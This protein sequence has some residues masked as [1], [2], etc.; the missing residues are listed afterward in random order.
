MS[1][2]YCCGLRRAEL[3]N[4][5]KLWTASDSQLSNFG[6]LFISSAHHMKINWKPR[7]KVPLNSKYLLLPF[8]NPHIHAAQPP[9]F[10]PSSSFVSLSPPR[11]PGQRLEPSPSARLSIC[12]RPGL[13]LLL[14]RQMSAPSSWAWR[15]VCVCVC[16]WGLVSG[17]PVEGWPLPGGESALTL[18]GTIRG[19]NGMDEPGRRRVVG[20]WLPVWASPCKHAFIP[21]W[22][23]CGYV[24]QNKSASFVRL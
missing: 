22:K 14:L 2:R 12:R 4:R 17:W 21:L 15:C 10:A 20:A 16:V 3:E 24:E 13:L 5:L 7:Q 8:S 9:V 6:K 11:I 19:N 1:L 23:A 18:V